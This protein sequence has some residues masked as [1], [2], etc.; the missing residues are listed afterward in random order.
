MKLGLVSMRCKFLDSERGE[1]ASKIVGETLGKD[2][3]KK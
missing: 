1:Q 2:V 3:A